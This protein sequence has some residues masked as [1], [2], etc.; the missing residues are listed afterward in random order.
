[1]MDQKLSETMSERGDLGMAKM[2]YDQL[3]PRPGRS[4]TDRKRLIFMPNTKE[5]IKVLRDDLA[6]QT[7]HC[8]LLEAQEQALLAC[9]RE[10]FAALQT[11]YARMLLELEAQDGAR[12][13]VLMD[14]EGQ[15]LTLSALKAGAPLPAASAHCQRWKTGCAGRWIGCK[16]SPGAI[17]R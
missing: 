7:R 12:K 16:P 3:G 2:M 9:D 14:E 8:K 15:A 4:T 11:Q 17:R 13:A 10:R 5:I 1:M 6:L